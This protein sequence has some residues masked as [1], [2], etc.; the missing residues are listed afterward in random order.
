MTCLNPQLNPNAYYKKNDRAILHSTVILFF[1]WSCLF[2]RD[3]GSFLSAEDERCEEGDDDAHD[4]RMEPANETPV[5]CCVAADLIDCNLGLG[6]NVGSI[7]HRDTLLIVVSDKVGVDAAKVEPRPES[8]DEGADHSYAQRK[9]HKLLERDLA[10]GQL[11]AILVGSPEDA[12]KEDN[13][14]DVVFGRSHGLGSKK[15]AHVHDERHG[16]ANKEAVDEV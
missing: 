7:H 12:Y 13:L 11:L 16:G 3:N 4:S 10:I 6:R 2:L 14:G 9:K 8:I 5:A 15:V 1:A